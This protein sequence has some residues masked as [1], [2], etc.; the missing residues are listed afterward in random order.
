MNSLWAP[1]TN[2]VSNF[3]FPRLCVYCSGELHDGD[4]LF[5]NLCWRQV[6]EVNP[7]K[8]PFCF[9]LRNGSVCTCDGF[10]ESQIDGAAAGWY[11]EE[12]LRTMVHQMKYSSKRRFATHTGESLARKI[13]VSGEFLCD[14]VIPVPLHHTRRRER[15]YNQTEMIAKG[16]C[17]VTGLPVAGKFLKRVRGGA[18]QTTRSRKERADSIRNSFAVPERK[19]SALKGKSVLLIDDVFTTGAT[20]SECCR[21]LKSAGAAKV[22]AATVALVQP[23]TSGL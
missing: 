9:N 13:N 23:E 8:C 11:F 20:L 22:Y 3:I 17:R 18:S 6:P 16:F 7:N 2:F 14:Y 4:F 5:C 12:P 21:I 1:L 10:K 15:G 19:I